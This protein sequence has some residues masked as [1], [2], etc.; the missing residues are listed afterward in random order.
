MTSSYSF[1]K[2]HIV[3]FVQIVLLKIGDKSDLRA[4]VLTTSYLFMHNYQDIFFN[5]LENVINPFNSK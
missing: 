1:L 5:N 3:R 4:D 2:I